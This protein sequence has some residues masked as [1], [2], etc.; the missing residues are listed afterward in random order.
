MTDE[1]Y[2]SNF[3]PI[4]L[5]N[6]THSCYNIASKKIEKFYK[7]NP[8]SLNDFERFQRYTKALDRVKLTFYLLEK[9]QKS[10]LNYFVENAEIIKGERNQDIIFFFKRVNLDLKNLRLRENYNLSLEYIAFL[11]TLSNSGYFNKFFFSLIHLYQF[12]YIENYKDFD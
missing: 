8:K 7:L 9:I 3:L 10:E 12:I 1:L 11:K 2:A 4:I 5:S 6:S